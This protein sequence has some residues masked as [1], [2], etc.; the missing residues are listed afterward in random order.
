MVQ[1]IETYI[2]GFKRI[3][4]FKPYRHILGV[5]TTDTYIREFKP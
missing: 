4:E 3:R 1:T 2:R 5:Q